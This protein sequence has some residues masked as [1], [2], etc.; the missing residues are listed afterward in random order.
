MEMELPTRIS[1]VA[2]FCTQG[3][4]DVR[5]VVVVDLIGCYEFTFN[6]ISFLAAY[7]ALLTS[8]TEFVWDNLQPSIA[9]LKHLDQCPGSGR[10]LRLLNF[11]SDPSW[12]LD[13]PLTF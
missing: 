1:G 4:L 9:R 5:R 2:Y 10:F 13:D 11:L 8:A 6:F 3:P 12:S 7:L